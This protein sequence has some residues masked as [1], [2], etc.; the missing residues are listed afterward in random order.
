MLAHLPQSILCRVLELC[1]NARDVGRAACVCRHLHACSVLVPVDVHPPY[2]CAPYPPEPSAAVLAFA[3]ARTSWLRSLTLYF[4]FPVHHVLGILQACARLRSLVLVRVACT[5]QNVRAFPPSLE[6]LEFRID[7]ATFCLSDLRH[8]H[9]LRRVKIVC[10][11]QPC[12]VTLDS[13]SN[14]EFSVLSIWGAFSIFVLRAPIASNVTL[15]AECVRGEALGSHTSVTI[16]T[17]GIDLTHCVMPCRAEHV[18][19]K[20]ATTLVLAALPRDIRHLAVRAPVALFDSAGLM[21]RA[22]T[23]RRLEVRAMV[24]GVD[25][26]DVPDTCHVDYD[27]AWLDVED[28]D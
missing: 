21:A 16:V 23:L 20:V 14:Q 7:E 12:M 22:G 6:H 9:R 26:G 1:G 3:R 19:L 15:D 27:D 2:P 18:S 5:L 25:G 24:M 10:Y 8:L 13:D 28:V 4:P 17:R 11:R